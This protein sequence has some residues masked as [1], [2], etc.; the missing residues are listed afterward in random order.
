MNR[1][2]LH[3][4]AFHGHRKCVK[5]LI[6]HGA[7][8]AAAMK[9]DITAAHDIFTH[10]SRPVE[11]LTDILDSSVHMSDSSSEKYEDV[12]TGVCRSFKSVDFFSFNVKFF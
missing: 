11:F 2:A 12:K 9:N 10:I 5:I 8:L 4:A 7:N 6:N 3:R 1:T